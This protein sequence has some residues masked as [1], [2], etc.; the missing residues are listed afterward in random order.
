MAGLRRRPVP[1][2]GEQV[3]QRAGALFTESV[4][5]AVAGLGAEV[6]EVAVKDLMLPFE[7]RRALTETFI[8]RE[9]G[10]AELERARA[11]AAALRSLANTAR[12]LEEHPALLQLRPLQ[13]AANPGTTLV[14]TPNGQPPSTVAVR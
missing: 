9:R 5:A 7:I 10:R 11:E 1:S 13:A 2:W 4:A 6:D 8:A 14:L 12:L 3:Q